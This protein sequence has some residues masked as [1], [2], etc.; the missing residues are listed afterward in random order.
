MSAETPQ[1]ETAKTNALDDLRAM[2][3]HGA[4]FATMIEETIAV[5]KD[6]GVTKLRA[7]SLG[8]AVKSGPNSDDFGIIAANMGNPVVMRGL[9][10]AQQ[11][12]LSA[13]I[14]DGLRDKNYGMPPGLA[15]MISDTGKAEECNCPECVAARTGSGTPTGKNPDQGASQD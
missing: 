6:K 14:I 11:D 15:A 13:E 2:G 3:Q 4:V 1:P 8:F 10:G 9:I 5:M 7:C 12:R